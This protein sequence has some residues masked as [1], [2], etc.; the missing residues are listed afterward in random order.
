MSKEPKTR[1]PRIQK[2]PEFV[3]TA[4]NFVAYPGLLEWVKDQ[5]HTHARPPEGEIVYR[6][7]LAWEMDKRRGAGGRLA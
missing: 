5:A 3:M 2:K 1:K 7:K 6:L 4:V